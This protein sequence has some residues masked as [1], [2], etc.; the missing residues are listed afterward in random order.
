MTNSNVRYRIKNYV[1]RIKCSDT[2]DNWVDLL[3]GYLDCLCD[4]GY[5]DEEDRNVLI[6]EYI[7]DT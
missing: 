1:E 2:T 5:I 6:N 4:F 7:E 3:I